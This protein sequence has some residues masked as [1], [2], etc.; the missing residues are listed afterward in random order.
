MSAIISSSC[1]YVFDS[2]GSDVD[3]GRRGQH[4]AL[5][6]TMIM[7]I[8]RLVTIVTILLLMGTQLSCKKDEPIE[9]HIT[10][11][12]LSVEDASC[13]EAWIKVS[14]L[15]ASQPRTVGVQ[16]DGQRVLTAQMTT[17]DSVFVVEGLLPRRTYS[18]VAQRLRD[19][20]VIDVSSPVQATTMDTTSHEF[21]FSFDTLGVTSSALTG[22]VILS[23]TLAFA[24]GEV[25]LLDSVGHFDDTPYNALKYDGYRFQ[26][27]RIQFYTVCGQTNR[28]P[29]P[30]KSLLSL[31]SNDV[32]FAMDGDEIARWDGFAQ[33]STWCLPF[34]FGIN[35][36]W[37]KTITNVY[38]VGD[39]GNIA[40]YDGSVWHRIESG[41]AVSL[42]DVWGGTNRLVGE[43]VVVVAA[44]NKYTAGETKLLRISSSGVVD[45]LPWSSQTLPRQSIW[46][47]QHSKLYTCGGGVFSNNGKGW[48]EA[49]G[50]PAIYTNRIR[51]NG[52]NDI[53]VAGDFGL[54][55]HFNGWTWHVYTEVAM[56]LGNYESVAIKGNMMIAVGWIGD[57]GI[58]VRGVRH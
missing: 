55:A 47:D 48:R 12:A 9:P 51:G 29:Y 42:N 17:T 52:D 41:T 44:G 27:F 11:I 25:Y 37:G 4:H 26:P 39:G 56:R 15:D 30:T 10:G 40:H 16:Q 31:G 28:T 38:A 49:I 24:T 34:S 5:K 20:S 8:T 58:I 57:Q 21:S 7:D 2:P 22:V 46:F 19:T 14:L 33:R 13:T 18:Y 54:L 1:T 53:V 45:T 35:N 32:W 3:C 23:D 43:N 50:I 6:E 36:L